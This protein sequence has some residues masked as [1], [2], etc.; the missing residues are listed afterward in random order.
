MDNLNRFFEDIEAEDVREQITRRRLLFGGAAIGGGSL[1]LGQDRETEPTPEDRLTTAETRFVAI[2]TTLNEA[3]IGDPQSSWNLQDEV[4]AAISA[5]NTILSDDFPD[6]PEIKQRISVLRTAT[7]YYSTLLTSLAAADSL[8]ISV[9]DSELE[10]LRH[11]GGI[12]HDPASKLDTNS[13]KQSIGHLAEAENAQS[14]V[15]SEGRTLVPDQQAVLD[16]L[17]TQREIFDRYI[18]AQQSYLD[19]ATTIEAGV[20]AYEQSRFDDAQANLADAQDVLLPDIS[21]TGGTYQLSTMGLTLDQY[22]ELF[23]LRQDGVAQLLNASGESVSE[24]K[25][26]SAVNAALNT[27]F[28]ARNLIPR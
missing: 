16:S 9:G 10:V 4:E 25:R 18:R 22:S 11:T 7:A 21:G 6:D 13:F 23:S 15:T 5:V 14:E 8:Y 19:S 17:R 1:L 2:A 3:D 24:D 27:F 12:E 20:R 26:Q 28:E